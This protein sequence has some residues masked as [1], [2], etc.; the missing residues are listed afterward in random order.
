MNVGELKPLSKFIQH[1][2]HNLLCLFALVFVR[3]YL[4]RKVF[5][6]YFWALFIKF[7]FDLLCWLSI[8]EC[9]I[10]DAFNLNGRGA[11]LLRTWW[12]HNLTTFQLQK[13]ERGK[14]LVNVDTCYQAAN[15]SSWIMWAVSKKV[16][17]RVMTEQDVTSY[18]HTSD[19]YI[20]QPVLPF[21]ER[22]ARNASTPNSS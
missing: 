15:R 13:G 2:F 19:P 4:T 9:E 10:K 21:C 16:E 1:P 7:S 6:F 5:H 8:K 17:V 18:L 11:L 14:A 20:I 22:R 3:N 12:Q